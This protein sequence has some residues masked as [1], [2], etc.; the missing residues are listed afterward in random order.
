MEVKQGKAS[1]VCGIQDDL[2]KVSGEVTVE[3]LQEI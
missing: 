3:W 2:L 1:R